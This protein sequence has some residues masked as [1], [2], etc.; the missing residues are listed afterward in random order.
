MRAFLLTTIVLIICCTPLFATESFEKIDQLMENKKYEEAISLL[1]TIIEQ[2]DE[3]AP[4]Y[5][6]LGTC[7]FFLEDFDEAVDAFDEAVEL[8]GTNAEYYLWL[9][10]A[11]GRKTRDAS[12]FKQPFLAPKIKDAYERSVELDPTLVDARIGLIQFNLQAPGIMGGDTDEAR[13]HIE[14]LIEMGELQ[15]KFLLASYYNQED[16]PDSAMIVY[17]SLEREIGNDPDYFNFYN[18]YGYMLLNQ[19]RYDDAIEKFEKQVELAPDRANSYDSLGDGY[20]AA[21]RKE[22]AITAY[23]KAVEIDPGFAPSKKNL[24]E[25]QG[26]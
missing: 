14:K 12:I 13:L 8:E 2:N 9:G 22:E 10:N 20:R 6:K 15:G 23:K 11:L 3:N 1:E 5:F 4:A 17:D 18:Q 16:K 21:G 7:W 26:E 24:E 25:L 19:K